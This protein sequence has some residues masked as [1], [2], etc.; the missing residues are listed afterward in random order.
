MDFIWVLFL[1]FIVQVY[2][3]L[4]TD[5]QCETM[6]SLNNIVVLLLSLYL[7]DN[8]MAKRTAGLVIFRRSN[9]Q[10]EYLML[11]PSKDGKVWSP[12]KGKN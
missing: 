2:Q 8:G 4:F 9:S 10:T 3:Y 5:I 6:S 11:K 1:R 7:I 12:P